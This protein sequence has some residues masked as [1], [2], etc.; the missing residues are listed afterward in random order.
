MKNLTL[1]TCSYNTPEVT[2]TMLRSFVA[3]HPQFKD[4]PIILMENSTNEQTRELLDAYEV[5][6]IPN[7]GYTHGRAVNEALKLCKTKHALLVDTDIIFM[8]NHE[9]IYKK[10]NNKKLTLLGE[11][12]GDRGGKKLHKRVAPWWCWINVKDIHQHNIQFFDEER[13]K[14]SFETDTRYDV[15]STMFEDVRKKDLLVGNVNAAFK[16]YVHYEGMSWY[17]NKF[18]E[19]KEDTNSLDWDVNG[20]HNNK[21]LY[22]EGKKRKYVYINE[23]KMFKDIPITG[24]FVKGW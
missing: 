7:D 1:I 12:Q 8:D 11:I 18:D 4:I 16:K 13:T 9:S 15:G 23:I 24:R 14:A 21:L 3:K 17:T 10:F 19:S 2:I 22:E 5:P 20:S 6:Y